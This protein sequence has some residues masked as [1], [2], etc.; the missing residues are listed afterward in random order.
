MFYIIIMVIA[1]LL[2]IPIRDR[3]KTRYSK[4]CYGLSFLVSFLPSGLRY[5]I[6]TDYFYTYV[7]Y[8]YWIGLGKR[9]YSEIGFN[10]LN[11]IIYNLSRDY[12]WLFFISAFIFLFFIYKA[13]WDNS[14]NIF[15]SILLIFIGQSYF[16]SM[17]LVRQAI[18]IAIVLYSYKFLKDKKIMKTLICILFA[19]LFHNSALIMIPILWISFLEISNVKKITIICFILCF[20]PIF[21][22][23][24][25]YIIEYTKY[26]WYYK[27]GLYTESIS[28]LLF[29]QNIIIL[30][31]DLYYQKIY[32]NKVT[33]EYKILSNINYIG[34]CT[35]ILSYNVPLI[36]R[37]VRYC[38]IF[39]I[40][41][42]PKILNLSEKKD[43]KKIFG[44]CIFLFFF[45]C[46]IYQIIICGG[47]GVVPYKS[48]FGG[49]K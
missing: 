2:I 15:Q 33:K 42:I 19:S 40:L 43:N 13:I 32:S 7:P 29:L 28:I 26:S 22:K 47:E 4:I 36:F 20:Q 12:R 6:G 44:T 35:M 45:V 16:Y 14:E 49:V 38:S 37:L 46:M 30:I 17:N 31:L 23:F 25:L 27:E 3:K 48:I 1:V 41:L 18:A 34:I 21:A 5:G 11:K 10:Y 8:F 39:Q 24:V 9:E